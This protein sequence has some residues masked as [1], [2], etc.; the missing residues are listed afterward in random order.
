MHIKHTRR[1]IPSLMRNHMIK[2]EFAS[3]I[4]MLA[5]DTTKLSG[6]G[7]NYVKNNNNNNF[8]DQMFYLIDQR[9]SC[10]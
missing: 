5:L 4:E 8:I 3:Y 1:N 10:F 9:R 7:R 2:D 6:L